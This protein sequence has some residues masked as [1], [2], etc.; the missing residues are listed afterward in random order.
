MST[1]TSA[2]G[3]A[4]TGFAE[5]A[6]AAGGPVTTAGIATAGP[7]LAVSWDTPT[8]I[9]A[10]D[11]SALVIT[12]GPYRIGFAREGVKLSRYVFDSKTG[13]KT[14]LTGPY[15]ETQ[16]GISMAVPLSSVPRLKPRVAWHATVGIDDTQ[17]ARCPA[18]G[19]SRFGDPPPE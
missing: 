14:Q 5:C 1:T 13:I 15:T 6:F 19:S 7:T 10:A 17:V 18:N 4:F 11:S 9:P 2:P 3:S 8:T 16:Q 12:V